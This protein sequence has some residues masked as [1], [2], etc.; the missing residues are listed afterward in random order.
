MILYPEKSS[1]LKNYQQP[2][3]A[4]LPR[5]VNIPLCEEYNTVCKTLVKPGDLVTEGQLIATA[6][7]KTKAP[8]HSSLPGIVENIVN[9][10]CPNGKTEKAIQISLKG[11]FTY[12]GKI[13]LPMYVTQTLFRKLIPWYFP[14]SAQWTQCLLIYFGIFAFSVFLQA[15]SANLH[16]HPVLHRRPVLQFRLVRSRSRA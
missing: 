14:R 1:E 3:N 16:R 9:C 8:I 12:L 4:F 5:S 2:Q 11:S 10:Q 15:V 13:S 6:V 7:S